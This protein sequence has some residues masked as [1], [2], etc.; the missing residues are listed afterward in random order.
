MEYGFQLWKLL[1]PKTRKKRASDKLSLERQAWS[2]YE[3]EE[4][5][6]V[7]KKGHTEEQILRALRQA[8]SGTGVPDLCRENGINE[9]WARRKG[10]HH[11]ML[12]R[13]LALVVTGTPFSVSAAVG[14][15]SIFGIHPE[16]LLGRLKRFQRARCPDS[17]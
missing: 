15:V 7:A 16:S 17:R 5:A 4:D 6:K 3:N 13:M 10:H 2:L 14:F 9:V 8:E 12:R 1:W 11:R